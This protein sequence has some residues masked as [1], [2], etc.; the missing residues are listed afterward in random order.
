MKVAAIKK[1]VEQ[2][3]LE[4]CRKA[5]Q[6]L[7][8][9]EVPEIEIEGADEGEQLTHVLGAIDILE[10]VALEGKDI[11]VAMRDFIERVRNSIS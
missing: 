5:E 10:H 6:S 1:L 8:E 3:T 9:G 11:K 2:Y 4:Q 7:M